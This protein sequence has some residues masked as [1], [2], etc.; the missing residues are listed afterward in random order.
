MAAVRVLSADTILNRGLRLAD[1]YSERKIER[2]QRSTNITR[3]VKKYGSKPIVYSKI[4]LAF[5]QTTHDDARIE[6]KDLDLEYMLMSIYFLRKYRTYDD[7]ESIFGPCQNTVRT[8]VWFYLGKISALKHDKIVWPA[9]WNDINNPRLPYFLVS[10]D[11]THTRCYERQ[12]HEFNRDKAYFSH[13]FRKAGY[14]WEI[15]LD[16]YTDRV[17][18]VRGPFPAGRGD[19]TMFRDFLMGQLR[20]LGRRGIADNGYIAKDLVDVL[21]LPNSNDDVEVREIKRRARARHEAFNRRLKTF[22]ILEHTFRSNGADKDAK[23]KVAFEAVAV[24]CQY[25]MDNGSPLFDV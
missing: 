3:F 17:V 8:W 1:F 15:G 5:Q 12:T 7:M 24:I 10:V 19:K 21:S 13:K 9:E 14:A 11:G 4:W 25:Q 18:S 16:V 6:A 2:A 20:G 22:D 23:Q